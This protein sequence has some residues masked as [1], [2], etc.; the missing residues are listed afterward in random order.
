MIRSD[1]GKPTAAMFA[2]GNTGWARE[3]VNSLVQGEPQELPEDYQSDSGRAAVYNAA[4]ALKINVKSLTFND[5]I[6]ACRL[7]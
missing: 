1:L 4:K 6:W 5:K 7:S 3:F 2:R